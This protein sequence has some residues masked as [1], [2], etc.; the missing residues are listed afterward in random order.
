ME[1]LFISVENYF[2]TTW[3]NCFYMFAIIKIAN[4]HS[5]DFRLNHYPLAFQHSVCWLKPRWKPNLRPIGSR[6]ESPRTRHNSSPFRSSQKILGNYPNLPDIWNL[7]L[8]RCR[9]NRELAA[10]TSRRRKQWKRWLCSQVWPMSVLCAKK[11]PKINQRA[12]SLSLQPPPPPPPKSSAV[13]YAP[14]PCSRCRAC[15][16][17]Q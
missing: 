6:M 3:L 12:F 5:F 9:R 17:T 2:V 8:A 14:L 16:T 10:W 11:E 7:L 4:S 13:L 15:T 1:K